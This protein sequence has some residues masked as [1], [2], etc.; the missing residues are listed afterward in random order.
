[1]PQVPVPMAGPA[2]NLHHRILLE[3]IPSADEHLDY[4]LSAMKKDRI[5]H[6]VYKKYDSDQEKDY[7]IAPYCI[8]FWRYLFISI[9]LYLI[10]PAKIQINFG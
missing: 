9:L 5:L 4:I 6:I 1:M 10:L 2:I 8:K 7:T 3:S